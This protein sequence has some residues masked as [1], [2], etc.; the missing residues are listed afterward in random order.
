MNNRD[1]KSLYNFIQK[2]Q[3]RFGSLVAVIFTL[4]VTTNAYA[5]EANPTTIK[6]ET[7]VVLYAVMTFLSFALLFGYVLLN[8]KKKDKAFIALYSCV[9]IVNLGYLSL[10]LAKTITAAMISNAIAYA[11]SVFLPLCMLESIMH[12]GE[13]RMHKSSLICMVLISI[14]V[15]A[16]AA[17]G[18]TFGLY[19]KSVSLE[20]INGVAVLNKVYGP[21]HIVYLI[22]LL[23][24]FGLM[25]AVILHVK[26]KKRKINLRHAILLLGLTLGNLLVWFVEQKID[27]DFEFLSVSYII[28]ELF[29]LLL[30]DVLHEYVRLSNAVQESDPANTE[31]FPPEM[32]M[33]FRE[34]SDRV[35][36]LTPA[37]HQIFQ[38][39][40]E[41]Y[42]LNEIADL[43]YISVNTA[44]K[45][46]T[47]L[48]RKL[49]IASREELR[50]YIE[51]FR[52]S[53]R[54]QDI[55]YVK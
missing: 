21:L 34:F 23:S 51:L 24:Y 49:E 14:L 55:Q 26:F 11:G 25:A 4:F 48:N 36:L 18:D 53:N 5:Q 9:F 6:V 52:R 46:N 20:F 16:L 42:S 10:A 27:F 35:K 43:L 13:V 39:Y 45:H 54:L 12:V 47:N 29:L 40:I 2:K 3:L 38:Y 31:V 22:Y 50:L 7:S 32:E 30:Y 37:E 17:S 8:K 41:G 33:L 28:T 15:F 1:L 19:Y 44:K